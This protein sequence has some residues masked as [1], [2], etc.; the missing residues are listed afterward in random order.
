MT[1][2]RV[3]ALGDE[4]WLLVRWLMQ[5]IESLISGQV[6]DR[7]RAGDLSEWSNTAR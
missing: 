4:L 6:S 1:G 3:C 5:Q 7:T 2:A